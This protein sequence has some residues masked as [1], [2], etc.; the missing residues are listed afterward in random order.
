VI[1]LPMAL[2]RLQAWV[3]ERL[4]GEP[5]MNRDNLDSMAVDN[6]ASGKLPGLE[7]LGI[8]PAALA[9]LAPGYLRR[10]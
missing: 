3:M 10:R 2:A 9:T 5:L 7:A 1:G 4:P 8:T 6:V